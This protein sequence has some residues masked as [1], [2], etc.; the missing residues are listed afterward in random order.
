MLNL[1]MELQAKDS[2]I[3]L[4]GKELHAYTTNALT[5]ECLNNSHVPEYFHYCTEFT[6]DQFNSLCEFFK[7]P[8]DPITP[9]TNIPLSYKMPDIEIQKLPVCSQFLLTLMKLRQNFYHKDL[10]F[11][12]QIC[13]QSVSTLINSWVD[14]MYDRLGQLSI[15]PHRDVIS[16]NLPVN[17]KEEFPNT[18]AI[19]DCTE[20][21]T[22]KPS[23]LLLQSQTY[24]T[25]K[26][27]NTLKSLVACDPRGAV[28]YV[29]AIFTGSLS[30]KE[31]FNQC[32]IIELLQGCIQCGYL[33]VGD[34]LMTDK[35]FLIEKEVE[36]IG[37]RLNIPPFARSNC[38]MPHAD[39]EMTKKIAKH[40]SCGKGNCQN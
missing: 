4:L 40:S 21:K 26:S 11:R 28:M 17:F 23:S 31:I 35:G 7:V 25:Y 15:W 13:V 38:Q 30:D 20:L 18:F 14:Y 1:K 29:S 27:S 36:E 37:L 3:Q 12:F 33:K 5:P 10:A 24:S 34:G 8:N 2:Q 9:Q 6:Y 32:N 16:Q 39:V 19:L 22:Q